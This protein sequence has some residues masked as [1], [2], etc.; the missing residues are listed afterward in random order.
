MEVSSCKK[1]R[2]SL[3]KNTIKFFNTKVNQETSRQEFFRGV[4]GGPGRGIDT[5]D[6][7]KGLLKRAGYIKMVGNGKYYILKQIPDVS[8]TLM[9]DFVHQESPMAWFKYWN[10]LEYYVDLKRRIKGKK[11]EVI[12]N[13]SRR[14]IRSI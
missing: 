3:W 11:K 14:T 9:R 5:R 6:L 12:L 8:L 2:Y 1:E 4:G 7:Y 13:D 10:G